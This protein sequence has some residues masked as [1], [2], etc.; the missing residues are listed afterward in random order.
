MTLMTMMTI[1]HEYEDKTM[2]TIMTMMMT[3]VTMMM[4]MMTMMMTLVMIA[5]AN[6]F[7]TGGMLG[8]GSNA[9]A[10]S[11]VAANSRNSSCNK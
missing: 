10:S 2:L 7:V 3:M 6:P 11:I 1:Y 9:L 4:T 8:T 5:D